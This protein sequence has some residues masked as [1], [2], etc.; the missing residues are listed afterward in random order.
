MTV[1]NVIAIPINFNEFETYDFV[2]AMET[3]RHVTS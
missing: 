2:H 3:P 1:M